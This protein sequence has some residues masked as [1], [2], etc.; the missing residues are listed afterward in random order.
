MFFEPFPHLSPKRKKREEIEHTKL[1]THAKKGTTVFE[2]GVFKK[3]KKLDKKDLYFLNE[4]RPQ[5]QEI[6]NFCLKDSKTAK[7][8]QHTQRKTTQKKTRKCKKGK[9]QQTPANRKDE[10]M[11]EKSKTK[12][13]QNLQKVQE[14]VETAKTQGD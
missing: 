10:K 3:K 8:K 1:Q 6:C 2:K 7:T 4:K 13:K 9:E 14:E 5:R 11:S 12:Q